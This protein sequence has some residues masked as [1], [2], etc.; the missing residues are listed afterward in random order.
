MFREKHKFTFV[1]DLSVAE[2]AEVAWFSEVRG[3]GWADV[4]KFVVE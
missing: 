4:L 2:V 3:V 1:F